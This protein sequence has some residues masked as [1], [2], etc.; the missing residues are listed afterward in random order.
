MGLR[1][2]RIDHASL[3]FAVL[4]GC[5]TAT[6]QT[7]TDLHPLGVLSN[8]LI[9]ET[10][11]AAAKYVGPGS[12]SASACH[13]N[14]RPMSK[15]KV[16]QNE[17][18][19]WITSDKH[20]HAYRALQEPL[21]KQIGAILKLP[22]LP[23]N[24]RRCLACHAL[25]VPPGAH[26]RDFDIAEGVNCESCHGPA[27]LWLEPHIEPTAKHMDLVER[28]HLYDNKNLEKRAEK[29]LSCH[30]GTPGVTVDHELIA[31]G[32][33][34]LTFELG[35]FSAAEP[36]HWAEKNP[37]GSPANALF[38]VRVWVVGQAVALK[39]SMLRFADY[40]K[41]GPW[42]EFSEMDCVTCHHALTGPQSWRQQ[43]AAKVER[44]RKPQKG[45]TILTEN[46]RITS[47]RY[48]FIQWLRRRS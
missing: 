38:D 10:D 41:S 44:T 7:G 39:Q 4:M 42:P 9:G 47:S 11:V 33:P 35:S 25:S 43:N 34:D 46:L 30:L 20:A 13:G 15:T 27:S 1:R 31:A 3:F 26:A 17:Y 19:T 6:C 14:I 45:M 48:V 22:D 37:D 32:H 12:C 18:S 2:V 23:E 21:G 24:S 29:C 16:W 5:A 8:A 40:A 28:L 36:P